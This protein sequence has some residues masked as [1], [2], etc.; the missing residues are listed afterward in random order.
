MNNNKVVL[1]TGC[2]SGFG[3]LT[4]LKFARS[5]WSVIASMRKIGTEAQEL[6]SIAKNEN[7]DLTVIKM[8]V[9][10]DVEVK[11]VITKI[12][13]K[14][15]KI[16]VLV[17]NAGFGYLGPVEDFEI[18]EVRELYNTNIFGV[19][20]TVK[21]VLPAMRKR[22]SG[23]II[24]ISSVNGLLSFGLYA[25]YSSSKFALETISEA[26][27]FEVKP[28]NIKVAIIEPGGFSTKFSQ[29]GKLAKNYASEATAYSGLKNP[30]SDEAKGKYKKNPLLKRFIDPQIV[31]DK[32]FEVANQEN[33]KLRY[34]V[35]IDAN[36]YTFLRKMLPQ[37]VWELLLHKA[38]G[39]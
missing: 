12:L 24:N 32:I 30:L 36:V 26:L 39:W 9:T 22:K 5:K 18:D 28:F 34:K 8:D 35:G 31:A 3:Y 23:T 29:K 19:L 25:M 10:H 27:R 17:N 20:R 13:E 7:L 15:H 11:N 21:A 38:Y 33:P 4:A 37:R 1:I 16:D 6:E 14:H 2:S